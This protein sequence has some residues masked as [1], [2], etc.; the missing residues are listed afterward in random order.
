M[1]TRI[2]LKTLV[3]LGLCA[4]VTFGQ[5]PSKTG[6]ASVNNLEMYYEIYGQGEPLVLI[7]GGGSTIQ[8]SF[9]RIIPQLSGHFTVIAV[10]LQNH[11]RSGFRS[12]PETFEQDADD[13]AA[14]LHGMGM[15][16]AS[17]FGFSNG[18]STAMQIGIRHPGIVLKLVV[19]SGA[20]KRD[21]FV[22][23]FF[24]GMQ[25][26]TLANMP[27]AL[28]EAFL[29]VNPDSTKLKTM[30]EK[31][32]ERMVGFKDWTDS[33]LRSITAPTLI[34]NG[35]ADVVTPKHALEMAT[36]IKNSRLLI[37]PAT[38]GSY[39]GTIET[40]APDSAMIGLTVEVI[41]HFLSGNEP[42]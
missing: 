39:I 29:Q 20:Y 35:D 23:G 34:I 37:L 15:I 25:K 19:A 2:L 3:T 41:Q 31:D 42:R 38:H 12:V 8:S 30:F 32:R 18:A 4:A 13:V 1:S 17:F 22:P 26:A 28:K 27:P 14:L 6:H 24:D 21:G 9:G 36:L 7:H 33:Q 16:K 40:P 10:E 5:P 11:G